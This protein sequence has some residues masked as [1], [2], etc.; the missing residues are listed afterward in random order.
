M[1]RADL[2][3]EGG[4]VKGIGLAGAYCHLARNGYVPA[5]VAGTSAGAII[6]SLVAAGY[7]ADELER[8]VLDDMEFR[9]FAD[10]SHLPWSGPLELLTRKGLHP[11]TYF[12]TWIRERLAEKGVARFGDLRRP[13]AAEQPLQ[14]I[15]S[16]VSHARLLVLPRDAG[17]L[18]VDPDALEVAA[19]VRMSMSIPVFFDPVTFRNPRD[20]HDVHLIVDGG[21]LSNYPVWLFDVPEGQEPRW[22]TFG[23]LLVPPST[24]DPLLPAALVAH[25]DSDLS[26]PRY[27]E[28]IGATVIEAHDRIY[29]EQADYARTISIDTLGV[30]TTQFSIDDDPGLK[31]RLFDS[32]AAA[33]AKFLSTWD[34]AGYRRE[35]R[36]G[37]AQASRHERIARRYER[38]PS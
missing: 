16:D 11:G 32:G 21:M 1:N 37:R 25:D 9:R 4:G 34:F 13:G 20:R 30:H 27:L 19:A 24:R 14:V 17:L 5:R 35:F 12:E 8:L 6:G 15:A 7:G 38:A 33:G 26:L 10:G 28:L 31:R 23:F 22:P 36:A 18:G 2:V 29:V 3:F